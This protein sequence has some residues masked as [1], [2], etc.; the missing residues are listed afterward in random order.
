MIDGTSPSA[1]KGYLMFAYNNNSLDY[2]S[3]A[4]C[5][6]LLI[7]KNLKVNTVGL[8][9]DQST[10]DY[11]YAKHGHELIDLAF[12]KLVIDEVNS[13]QAGKR[14]FHDTRYSKF[15]DR[16][17]NLNRPN[18]FDLTPFDQTVMIDVDYLMLDN[19]MDLV[20]DNT[21]DFMCNRKTLDLDHKP[22][23]FGFDNR[24]NDMS[25]PLYWATAIYF[26]KT[27][28]S[29]L[30]FQLMNFIR[31]NYSYYQYLYKFQDSGYFRN[32]YALSIAI[33]MTNN[34]M[35]YG[36]IA[37]LPVD[38]LLFSMETDEFHRFENNTCIFT[39]ETTEGDF[40]MRRVI[41]N[42]HVMNKRSILRREKEIIKYATS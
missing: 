17:M 29:Q 28:S 20:W 10:V 32:D 26:K 16:Y 12:D 34:L 27:E 25:I 23:N 38:H 19:S 21:E 11:M 9:T 36:S 31:E 2:A 42:V 24:F 7:K 15:V 37:H 14:K 1:E 4:L 41:N 6:S 18:V 33:H 3:L 40:H 35:E 8:V 5:N 13:N 22:N 30:I 39:T